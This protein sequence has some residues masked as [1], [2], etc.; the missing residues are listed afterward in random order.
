M[1]DDKQVK[2]AWEIWHL[3]WRLNDLIWDHYEEEFTELISQNRK[4]IPEDQ[5]PF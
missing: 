4:P 1:K 3:I 2:I 5:W